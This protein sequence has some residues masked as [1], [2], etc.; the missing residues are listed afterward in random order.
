MV[1]LGSGIVQNGS[2]DF[3]KRMNIRKVEGCV[4]GV[5]YHEK[6]LIQY[7]EGTNLGKLP[8]GKLCR[9]SV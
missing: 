1:V 3:I 2:E 6:I 8:T 7:S 5:L 9:I 4:R